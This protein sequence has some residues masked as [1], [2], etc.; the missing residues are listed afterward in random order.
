LISYNDLG[1][2]PPRLVTEGMPRRR[3]Q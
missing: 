3:K 2:L 1:H